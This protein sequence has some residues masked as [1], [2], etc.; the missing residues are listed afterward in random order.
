VEQFCAGER[1]KEP[2]AGGTCAAD[3]AEDDGIPLDIPDG[4]A[5]YFEIQPRSD[6][7]VLSATFLDFGFRSDGDVSAD[8]ESAKQKVDELENAVSA[9]KRTLESLK[10]V[11]G[12]D[13]PDKFGPDDELHAIRDE[14]FSVEEGKYEYELCMFGK[15]TQ[16]DKGTKAGGTDLGKWKEANTEA[17]SDGGGHEYQQRVWKW[18]N[19]A[20]CWNGPQRSATA[21]VTCGAATVVLSADEPSTCQYVL[22]MESPIACDDDFR[23][24]HGL[25]NHFATTA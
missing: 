25:Q 5:G 16:K 1:T 2:A 7:D 10:E 11:I 4:Y 21:Y 17:V 19:G 12:G 22:Q 13:D 8:I 14:C 9:L 6:D 18:D 23:I 15:A 20:K 3:T 24:R